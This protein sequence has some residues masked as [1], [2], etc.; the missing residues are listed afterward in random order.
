MLLT[1]KC[2]V[3]FTYHLFTTHLPISPTLHLPLSLTTSSPSLAYHL[4]LIYIPSSDLTVLL[5]IPIPNLTLSLNKRFI[6]P[7]TS[8]NSLTKAHL[9]IDSFYCY[10][11]IKTLQNLLAIHLPDLTYQ[12]FT[13]YLSI[14]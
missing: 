11:F 4:H 2:Q 10:S 14:N 13:T 1:Y 7:L 3:P 12:S 5:A 6:L 8:Q 9:P